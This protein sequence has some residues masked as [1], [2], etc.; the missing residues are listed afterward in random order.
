MKIN[1][2]KLNCRPAD[3]VRTAR[4]GDSVLILFRTPVALDNNGI[5]VNIPG[6]SV[7]VY[8]GGMSGKFCRSGAQELHFDYISFRMNTS[9]RQYLMSLDF[10]MDKPIRLKDDMMLASLIRGMNSRSLRKGRN[11]NEFM[12]LSMR[13]IFIIINDAHIGA[14]EEKNEEIPHIRSSR[15]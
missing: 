15:L 4:S 12:E 8:P 9:E 2:I 7:I 10:P 3:L 1:S 13:L 11:Y 14:D 5:N 6:S